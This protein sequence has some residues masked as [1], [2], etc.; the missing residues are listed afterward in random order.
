MKTHLILFFCLLLSAYAVMAQPPDTA[1]TMVHYKFS[2]LRDTTKPENPYTENMMLL[3]GKKSTAYKSY[4]ARLAA[5]DAKKQMQ[6]QMAANGGNGP[7]RINMKK[8]GSGTEY[9]LFPV[10][11]KLI[12]KEKLINSYLIDEPFPV[13]NWQISTDT[14]TFGG[15]HCQKATARFKG[16]DYT[17]WFCPDIPF[18]GGPWKLSGLPGLILEA[19]DTKK[20][21]VFKFDGVEDISKMAAPA[22]PANDDAQPPGGIR[23]I[24]MDAADEDP[25]LI[26]LPTDAIKTTESEFAKLK[27]AMHKDP[28]A[29]LQSAMAGS[30]ANMSPNG[31]Q[32]HMSFKPGP[33]PVENN[34]IELP[35]KK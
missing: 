10:E 14:A 16:R 17:A 23:L 15:L 33:Q 9:Y 4:D 21:V 32:M 5:L 22:K 34:P 27:E 7:I 25:R 24:G 6:E 30:G 18:H 11:S 31:P 13:I 29:F 3:L 35:E 2:H 12:R 1:S 26:T 19:F 28:N 8:S 20:Q